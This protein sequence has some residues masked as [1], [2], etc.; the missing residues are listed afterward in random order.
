MPS[1]FSTANPLEIHLSKA[2]IIATSL[3]C[4]VVLV[5]TLMEIHAFRVCRASLLIIVYAVL[6]LV[7]V[8][9]VPLIMTVASSSKRIMA[10]L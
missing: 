8:P 2:T 10:R 1:G 3:V 5:A 4:L 6:V 7:S 9:L